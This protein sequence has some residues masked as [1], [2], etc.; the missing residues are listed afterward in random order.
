MCACLRGVFENG[1]RCSCGQKRHADI[2]SQESPGY[3]FWIRWYGHY[4]HWSNGRLTHCQAHSASSLLGSSFTKFL[5]KF[6]V[7]TTQKEL[8]SKNLAKNSNCLQRAFLPISPFDFR[9]CFTGWTSQGA[10]WSFRAE[11]SRIGDSDY[12]FRLETQTRN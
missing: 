11:F 12:E 9:M 3:S 5:V 7:R 4:R 8:F 10:T 2:T 6:L 1:R